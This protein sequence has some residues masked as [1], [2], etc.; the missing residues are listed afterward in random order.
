V[1]AN[2]VSYRNGT[3]SRIVQSLIR[4]EGEARMKSKFITA[5][6][7]L[8]AAS[9]ILSACGTAAPAT[10]GALKIGLIMVGPYND[11]GWSQAHYEALQW[12][13]KKMPNVTFD[14]VDKV[15][16]ADR[17]NTKGTQVADDL[18][19]KGA[20]VI[21]FNSDDFKDDALETAKKHPDIP[22]IHASG[23]YSWKEGQ[24]FKDQKNL[25]NIMGQM[26]FGKMM[27]GCAAA[28]GTQTGKIGFLGPLINEE[29]RRLAASAFLGAKYCWE[30]VLGKDPASL[31]FKV[32]W[33]G[34]WFNI[35]GVTLDPTKVADDFYNG[36]YDVVISSIDTP[37]AA[38]EAKK[39]AEAGKKVWY[40]H[41]DY[42]GGCDIAPDVCLGVPYFNW[43]PAY[44]AASK[45]ALEGKLVATFDWN[46]PDWKD[47]KNEDTS[48]VG[49]IAGKALG[50]KTAKLNDFIKGMGDKSIV[51]FKGPL[52]YQDGSVFLKDGETATPQQIW[53]L[54]QLLQGMEGASSAK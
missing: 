45:K 1:F 23:D 26:E 7:A 15:N 16:P 10:S 32:T 54:A 28:L 35:P 38:V 22:V 2:A 50:D 20:K 31:S 21:I 48:A 8:A 30:K 52:N 18:I 47:I 36:G 43:G 29:T 34:F 19:A 3:F 17:P 39:A 40:V 12:V 42:A 11:K 4:K 6:S 25:V 53:Y 46:G 37:E 24:N 33:I 27:G 9:L 14:Y 44:L 13:N 5:A 41:Y 49:F 51:L